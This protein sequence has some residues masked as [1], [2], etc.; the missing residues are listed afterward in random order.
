[1]YRPMT[2]ALLTAS[3]MMPAVVARVA[4]PAGEEVSRL[5]KSGKTGGS[6][7]VTSCSAWA[8]KAL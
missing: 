7:R 6:A 3:G 4:G 8:I 2:L 5:D 1:M